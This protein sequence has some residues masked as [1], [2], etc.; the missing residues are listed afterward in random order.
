MSE[1]QRT[2]AMVVYPG[3]TPLDM[4]GPLQVLGGLSA[5]DPRFEIAVV[6]E[7]TD[8]M[9]TDTPLQICADRAFDEVPDPFAVIVPGG[10]AP[11][12]RAMTDER[13][14]EYLR[15]TAPGARLMGSV[16]TGSLVLG[17]A[18][19]LTGREATSHWAFL[20]LL[21]AFGA[22]PVRRRWVTDGPV[23]TAAGVAAGIDMALHLVS[24]LAGEDAARRV[25]LVIEYD[26]EPPLGPLDWETADTAAF[27]PSMPEYAIREGLGDYP[28]LRERLATQLRAQS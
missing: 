27:S 24:T 16:C 15:D 3:L 17:A 18:G 14:Q 20:P 4:V 23:V 13:L 22:T 1:Q 8:P 9:P 19:L 12:M 21:A 2:I 28:E 25:Q 10:M 11:T 7:H 5:L 26:P 6:G